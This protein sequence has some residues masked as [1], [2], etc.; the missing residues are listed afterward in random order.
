MNWKKAAKWAFLGFVVLAV[1][2]ESGLASAD[3]DACGGQRRSTVGAAAED[4]A[5]EQGV[6]RIVQGAPPTGPSGVADGADLG[7]MEEGTAVVDAA[8]PGE[9]AETVASASVV[10]AGSAKEYRHFPVNLHVVPGISFSG[11]DSTD[12]S[13]NFSLGLLGSYAARLD[14]AELSSFVAWETESARGA[15]LTAGLG[16]VGGPLTGFQAAAGMVL[17]SGPVVGAQA[18]A[19]LA[20][21]TGPVTGF[22]GAA[23]LAVVTAPV[24]GFQGAAGLAVATGDFTGAQLAAG[25]AVTTGRLE[26]LQAAAGLSYTEGGLG[27]QAGTISVATGDFTGAQLGVVNVSWGEHVGAQVGVLN[28]AKDIDYPVGIVSVVKEGAYHMDAWASDTAA[29]SLALRMGS[30]YI[31]NLFAVGVNPYGDET[32]YTLGWG[33]GGHIELPKRF[34]LDIDFMTWHLNEPGEF[35]TELN[36]LSKLRVAAGYHIAERFA[37]FAGLS[38][39]V[40]AS[41]V[42]KGSD[43]RWIGA[44]SGTRSDGTFVAAWP[45][46]FAGVRI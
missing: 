45:G 10:G 4:A 20:V 34:F 35:T 26:G 3:E 31:H 18:A 15:Q 1:Q 36:L 16:V 17:A 21:G 30:R 12:A 9:T 2:L 27:V 25:L 44:S 7:A 22:Q 39:N 38:A 42:G 19:G 46:F 23:G 6:H 43:W 29:T 32:R 5:A 40:F 41:R 24:T 11:F 14:G 28:I 13:Q 37:V 8:A 33:I